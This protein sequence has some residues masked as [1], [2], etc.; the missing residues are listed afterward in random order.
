MCEF[1]EAGLLV[2]LKRPVNSEERELT[3]VVEF[4][5]MIVEFVRL[6]CRLVVELVLIVVELLEFVRP[7]KFK[8]TGLR[9]PGKTLWYGLSAESLPE[10]YTLNAAFGIETLQ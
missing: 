6:V 2:L 8:G 3:E 7:V 5:R 1:F 10:T 4:G 9:I